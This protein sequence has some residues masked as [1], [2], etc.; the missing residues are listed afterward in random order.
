[1]AVPYTNFAVEQLPSKAAE[2]CS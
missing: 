2:L 1:M